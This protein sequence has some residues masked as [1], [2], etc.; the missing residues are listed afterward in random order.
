MLFPQLHQ[1]FGRPGRRR[2][3]SLGQTGQDEEVPD[4]AADVGFGLV[5]VVA[6]KDV[7]GRDVVLGVIGVEVLWAV[8]LLG[9]HYSSTQANLSL[10]SV[11]LL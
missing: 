2:C 10:S 1:L 9:G 7:V 8:G 11:S 5:P 3:P 4:G 6:V